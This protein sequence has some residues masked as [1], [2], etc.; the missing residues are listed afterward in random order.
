MASERVEAT[1]AALR[2]AGYGAACVIGE[3]GRGARGEGGGREGKVELVLD[4]VL[5]LRKSRK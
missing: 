3:V 4:G 1:L 2:A 5:S